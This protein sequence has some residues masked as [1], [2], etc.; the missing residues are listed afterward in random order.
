MMQ[1]RI[2]KITEFCENPIKAQEKVFDFLISKGENT[3]FGEE[4]SFQKID[5]LEALIRF[6][7]LFDMFSCSL[8]F[9]RR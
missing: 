5:G 1:Q 8:I 2:N 7:I 4:H 3:A 9:N 6:S